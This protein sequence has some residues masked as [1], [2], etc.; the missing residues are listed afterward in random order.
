MRELRQLKRRAK[1][2]SLE[3][4]ELK[5]RGRQ[6]KDPLRRDSARKL[7]YRVE[8]ELRQLEK[9]INQLMSQIQDA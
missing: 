3:L 5:L 1:N 4:S 8:G 7:A 9:Q 2:T 6:E